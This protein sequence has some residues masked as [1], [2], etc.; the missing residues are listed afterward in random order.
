MKNQL[1]EEF[2]FHYKHLEIYTK[3]LKQIF[4]D[5]D[6]RQLIKLTLEGKDTQGCA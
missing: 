2:S 5:T 1:Y 4:S 3:Y 6:N